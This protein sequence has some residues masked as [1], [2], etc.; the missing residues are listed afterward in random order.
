MTNLRRFIK[1]VP[2][3][4]WY[5]VITCVVIAIL[6]SLG[7]AEHSLG[8]HIRVVYLH[9]TWVWASLAAFIAAAI[10]GT[11]GL[12]LQRKSHHD[13]SKAFGRTGIILWVTY[14]PLSLW[15]M[16]ANWNGLFLA[17]PRWRLA[18]VFA[19]TGILLQIG[20]SLIN[21]P[22]VTSTVN[23]VYLLALI[24]VIQQTQNV[25]HP[26]S[27]ILSTSAWRIQL[28]FFALLFVILLAAF[29]IARWWYRFESARPPR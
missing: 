9:A 12:L 29:Q 22:N 27:A 5:F 4:I 21:R 28:F 24:V 6:T 8:T 18:L 25:M 19:V 7:P 23:I 14:L 15:A 3:G 17:E 1:V 13:W 20:I 26:G 16:Q 2:A 10:F 11:L